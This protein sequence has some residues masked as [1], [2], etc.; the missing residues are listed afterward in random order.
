MGLFNWV[1]K[2]VKKIAPAIGKAVNKA[3]SLYDKG[4]SMYQQY[5]SIVKNAPVIGQF[6]NS[7]IEKGENKVND[8]LKEKTGMNYQELD[9]NINKGRNLV[10]DGVN[11]ASSY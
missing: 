11:M 7:L 6:A 10:A 2:A 8:F 9:T 1:S 4:K 3:G 5:S